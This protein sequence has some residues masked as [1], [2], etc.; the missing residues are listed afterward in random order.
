M[1][2]GFKIFNS[3]GDM[4]DLLNNLD[5]FSVNPEGLGVSFDRTY[6]ETNASFLLDSSKVQMG[7]FNIDILFG[8]ITGES[9]ERYDDLIKLLNSPP[10]RLE[11]STSVGT[12][13]R[14]C[15]LND[16]SKTEI[17][18]LN[19]MIETLVLD[20]TSPWYN[21]VEESFV[22]TPEQ[23]GDG[24]IYQ[25]QVPGPEPT[26]FNTPPTGGYKAGDIWNWDSSQVWDGMNWVYNF[27]LAGVAS[28][29]T[30]GGTNQTIGATA[31][32]DGR[33]RITKDGTTEPYFYVG[34]YGAT[35]VLSQNFI[36]ML[37]GATI[38]FSGRL[39][40]STNNAQPHKLV[41]RY[42]VD[43]VLKLFDVP[44]LTNGE[45]TTANTIL[46]SGV[47][48]IVMG[49]IP[50]GFVV[51]N[52][53]IFSDL[54]LQIGNYKYEQ[55]P[56]DIVGSKSGGLSALKSN[57]ELVIS[58]WAKSSSIFTQPPI[59]GYR[60]DDLWRWDD[61]QSWDSKN[62]IA[63]VDETVEFLAADGAI[64]GVSTYRLT[65][66]I[67]IS[68]TFYLIGNRT[69]PVSTLFNVRAGYYDVEGVFIRRD[70]ISYGV[71]TA[72]VANAPHPV[73]PPENAA[74]VRLCFDYTEA[75]YMGMRY[76][77][78]PWVISPKDY[79][80]GKETAVFTPVQSN[81]ILD[82]NDMIEYV[83]G[84]TSTNAVPQLAYNQTFFYDY[85]YGDGVDYTPTTN[86]YAYN[87]DYI[88]E[89]R[90][91]G[92]DGVFTITNKSRYL[93]SAEGSPIEIIING[94]AKNPYWNLIKGSEIIQSD[95]FN[96][97][98]PSGYKLVV[99]SIPSEQKA[100]IV[101]PE[102]VESN[103]YQQQRLELTNF[104]TIP[105]GMS[106]LVFYNCKDID[107]RYREE[108]VIV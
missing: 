13:S 87:Y 23:D 93:G 89:G 18:D 108:S 99:S 47:T 49:I 42:W 61:T 12:W 17:K 83:G 68:G 16:L 63:I 3:K 54:G 15:K 19:I 98:I 34:R 14:D 91:N 48:N 59:Y 53:L 103:V 36:N 88:Y 4:I 71:S 41:I 44:M 21:D 9:Y 82:F 58:D 73:T 67:N 77:N 8:A 105:N 20:L 33:A 66:K 51:G 95:G 106:Q 72:A 52:S 2:R 38:T 40:S 32:G 101:T 5:F 107:Y 27:P 6:N 81:T 57:T 85:I 25:L 74:T 10:Y 11:Y 26:I 100:V 76:T 102:G 35:Q 80:N 75:P 31:Y 28:L 62:Q 7:Q 65:P 78:G 1:T 84:I 94:P 46:P 29:P 92:D 60:K 64:T 22:P 43:G 30:M 90:A 104:V 55:N 50:S 79:V 39:V 97:N 45:I 69:T 24:K 86:I 56:Y 70:V 37:Q 96:I